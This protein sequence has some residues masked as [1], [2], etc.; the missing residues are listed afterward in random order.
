MLVTRWSVQFTWSGEVVASEMVPLGGWRITAAQNG[1]SPAP[2][3]TTTTTPRCNATV[4]DGAKVTV[5]GAGHGSVNGDYTAT[6]Q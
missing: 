5:A 4:G 3:V 6:V 1:E 2:V